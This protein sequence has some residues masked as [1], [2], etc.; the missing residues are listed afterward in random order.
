MKWIIL[1][2]Q[3]KLIEELFKAMFFVIGLIAKIKLD[4]KED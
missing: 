4:F 3:I 1:Y 2:V